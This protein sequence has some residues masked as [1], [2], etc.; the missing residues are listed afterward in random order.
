MDAPYLRWT[1]AP[2]RPLELALTAAEIV[3]GRSPDA[4][5]VLT[6]DG[7]SRNHAKIMCNPIGYILLDLNSTNGTYVNEQQVKEHLL[8]HGDRIRLGM[9]GVEVLFQT[10]RAEEAPAKSPE[11]EDAGDDELV[12]KATGI[13]GGETAERTMQGLASVFPTEAPPRTELEKISYILDFH[14]YFEKTF[15]SEK[16]FRQILQ[17]ALEISGAERG[18]VLSKQDDGFHYAL[19]LNGKGKLLAESE[20]QTSQSIVGRVAEEGKA[21]FMTQEISEEFAQKRSILAMK[22]RAIACLPL[23]ALS[24]ESHLPEVL[25]ILYLDST[26]RMH[27]L[28][29]LD[30][31][32]L[33]KL[34]EEAGA[35]LEKLDMI[36]GLEERKKIEAE[37]A[38]AEE[39][40]R[41]LL[42][43]ALPSL[44]N[45]QIGA[46]SQP[47]RNV[48]GDFYDFLPLP[49][50]ELVGVLADV[51]G[52]GISAALLG[53]LL[54]G[55]LNTEFQSTNRLA[56]VLNRANKL[57]HQKSQSNRFVTLFLFLLDRQGNGQFVGAGHNPAYLFRAA[58]GTIEELI[59][60]GM[61][62]GM[63]DFAAYESAPFQ[64]H[65]G[66]V[67]L[68]YSDGVTEAQNPQEEMFGEE[69]LREIIR[70]EAPSGIDTLQARILTAIE[71][72]THGKPQ[73]D[74]I[75]LL[76][77]QRRG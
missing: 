67:L 3:I 50:G 20:F 47:T 68:V 35:V 54:Q 71:E 56:E 18:F 39:T 57:V 49:A 11:M 76:L 72:F 26:Q 21:V 74:D 13:W 33:T 38:L 42:P 66:D 30:Q 25:G 6:H 65:A 28:T 4:D 34:A 8:R 14:Y 44:E 22:L 2:N 1:V 70:K 24:S 10:H 52:K 29:G 43:Q 7:V 63:F 37:M 62:L 36:K 17:S 16:T 32:I 9:E 5:I 51:S 69:S 77:V 46:F 41:S 61:I 31:K 27:S 40:Q 23:E 12:T 75:T 55:I 60:K 59:S 58:T 19:G 45:F 64:L 73:S 48:G 53:S 15:S